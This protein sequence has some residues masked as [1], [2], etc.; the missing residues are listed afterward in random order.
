MPGSKVS[1]SVRESAGRPAD[2]LPAHFIG[3]ASVC[4]GGN[5]AELAQQLGKV[6]Y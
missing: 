5:M 1:R 6:V 3:A 2:S 4:D